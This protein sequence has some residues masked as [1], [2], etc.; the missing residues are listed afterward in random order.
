MKTNSDK[1]IILVVHHNR[2]TSVAHNTLKDTYI[3]KIATSGARRLRLRK[4]PLNLI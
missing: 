4:R 3:I 2:P 1:R